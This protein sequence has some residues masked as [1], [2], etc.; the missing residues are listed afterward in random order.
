MKKTT[1]IF[2]ALACIVGGC[3]QGTNTKEIEFRPKKFNNVKLGEYGQ[4]QNPCSPFYPLDIAFMLWN[5]IV[6]NAPKKIIYYTKNDTIIPVIPVCGAHMITDKRDYKYYELAIKTFYIRKLGEETFYSGKMVNYYYYDD[7]DE[8]LDESLLSL[9]SEE[10]EVE[11][12]RRI[13]E[14]QKYTDEELDHGQ[15]A[16]IYFNENLMDYVE[17]P[18]EPGIYE[19]Y[20]AKSGLK[21]NRVKVEIIFKE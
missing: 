1:I 8:T 5:E 18:F 2:I 14:A 15:S 12:Q 17:M 19:I 11:R 20:V 13:E 9:F 16:P 10:E 3:R 4:E 6:I 21:S 7:D